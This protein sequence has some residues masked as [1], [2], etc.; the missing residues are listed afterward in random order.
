MHSYH[1][2][3]TKW[4]STQIDRLRKLV[5]PTVWLQLWRAATKWYCA[6]ANQEKRQRKRMSVN[7]PRLI[8]VKLPRISLGWEKNYTF[9][10]IFGAPLGIL[11]G[12]LRVPLNPL[13]TTVMWWSEGVSIRPPWCPEKRQPPRQLYASVVFPAWPP[14]PYGAER[15][16]PNKLKKLYFPFPF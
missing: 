1:S 9:A 10:V 14:S 5:T 7:H 11:G 12:Q 2:R 3:I 6:I 4:I 16:L 15:K 8:C 13:N